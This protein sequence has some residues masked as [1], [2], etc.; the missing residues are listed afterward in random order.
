MSPEDSSESSDSPGSHSTISQ[1]TASEKSVTPHKTPDI[2]PSLSPVLVIFMVFD[3]KINIFFNFQ[4][5]K[6]FTKKEIKKEPS[7]GSV[8]MDDYRKKKEEAKLRAKRESEKAEKQKMTHAEVQK[9]Y[10]EQKDYENTV[11]SDLPK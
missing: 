5:K 7:K 11:S 10:Q 2:L 3:R 1:S 8:V 9:N 6:E 4:A